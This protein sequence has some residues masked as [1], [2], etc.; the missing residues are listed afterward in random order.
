MPDM[1]VA[2]TPPVS[3]VIDALLRRPPA[4]LSTWGSGLAGKDGPGVR[5]GAVGSQI[6]VG[7]GPLLK[8]LANQ[9]GCHVLLPNQGGR[10]MTGFNAADQPPVPPLPLALRPLSTSRRD[11]GTYWHMPGFGSWLDAGAEPVAE[12]PRG[13]K[14]RPCIRDC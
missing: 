3:T 14:G 7:L 12:V 11:P 6:R 2:S 1:P 10:Q 13:A 5:G 8:P 9:R 4:M